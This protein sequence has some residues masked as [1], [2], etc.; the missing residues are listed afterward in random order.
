MNIFLQ[1]QNVIITPNKINTVS[2]ITF[3]T[4]PLIKLL[5][6]SQKCF[7]M[8]GLLKFGKI[9]ASHIWLLLFLSF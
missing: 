1:D 5:Q 3:T 8:I 7:F 2:L 4:Q 9:Q 6:L